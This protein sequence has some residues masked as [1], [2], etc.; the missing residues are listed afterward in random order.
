MM[1]RML[2]TITLALLALTACIEK[3]FDT[4]PVGSDA[5]ELETNATISDLKEYFLP[6]EFVEIDED[7]VVDAIVVAD[8]EAGNFY[9]K[10]VLQDETGG[11]EIQLNRTDLYTEFEE[12][13][14]VYLRAQGLYISDFEGLVQ[15]GAAPFTNNSGSL[16]LARVD[17]ALIGEHL[18]RGKV[19]GVPDAKQVSIGELGVNDL[20][21]LVRLCD[22]QFIPSDTSGQLADA[23][24]QQTLN[25]TLEDCNFNTLIVRTSGFADVANMDVPTCSGCITG[26]YSTFRQDKQVFVRDAADLAFDGPRCNGAACGSSGGGTGGGSGGGSGGGG[27]GEAVSNVN[28]DF[29]GEVDREEVSLDGWLNYTSVAGGRTW[30]ARDF[31]GN[32]YAQATAFNDDNAS[33]NTWLIT[34]K[35]DLDTGLKISFETATAFHVHQG[36]EVVISTDYDGQ[37]DPAGATWTSIGATIADASS[38]ENNWIDSGEISLAAHTGTG[39]VAFHY[40]GSGSGNTSTYRVD[41]VIISPQ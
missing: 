29:E 40:T 11:I 30:L 16:Q 3:D 34:P 19:V 33:M 13:R 2:S 15:L 22:V 37:G 25:K 17:N 39:Y 23:L 7:L 20:S 12:G 41:D 32:L 35:L 9:K 36:L 8:D 21:T 1:Y 24:A 27:T 38:G 31:N 10:L 5:V 14:L 28:E 6:G 4:P 26:V 18:F